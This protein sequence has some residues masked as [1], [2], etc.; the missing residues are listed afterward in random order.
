MKKTGQIALVSISIAFTLIQFV[1][2]NDPIEK[3]AIDFILATAIAWFVGWH[4]DK[5]K[6]Y[7][8][9][10]RES[11]ESYKQLIESLPECVIIHHHGIILYVNKAAR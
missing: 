9:E 8:K 3:E 6:F 10:R 4:L 7:A 2:F 11:E 5:V 1:I